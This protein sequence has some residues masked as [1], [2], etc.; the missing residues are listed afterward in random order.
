MRTHHMI[1]TLA[2]AGLL[3]LTGCTPGT[4]SEPKPADKPTTGAPTPAAPAS[5]AP[6]TQSTTVTPAA[7]KPAAPAKTVPNFVGQVL[8]TAQDGAQ[9]EGFFLLASHDS[10]G[11]SRMQVLDRNWKVCTQTPAAGTKASTDTKIDFGT[12]KIEEACP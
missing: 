1:T 4:S 9:A 10:L 6:A 7:S 3:A 12:V 5:S 8:Q 11:Q 2:A